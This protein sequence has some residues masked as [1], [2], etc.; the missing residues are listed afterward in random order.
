MTTLVYQ[1]G[2]LYAD[3]KQTGLK[4]AAPV[5]YEVAYQ[6]TLAQ[7]EAACVDYNVSKEEYIKFVDILWKHPKFDRESL[8]VSVES[9]IIDVET[10]IDTKGR[11]IVQAFALAGSITMIPYVEH[12]LKNSQDIDLAFTELQTLFLKSAKAC[13][14]MPLDHFDFAILVKT[15]RGCIYMRPT[16]GTTYVKGFISKYNKN[17]YYAVGSG[18]FHHL[19]SGDVK[20]YITRHPN[21]EW[22][23][24]YDG[25]IEDIDLFYAQCAA[26]DPMTN[27]VID[28]H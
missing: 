16:L 25:Q 5:S 18:P 24:R 2:K 14:D 22:L 21:P 9:K 7:T 19:L 1:N 26:V 10:D 27:T 6:Y 13:R 12:F 3:T 11:G 20:K 17:S 28:V 4:Q 15:D 8:K 23:D